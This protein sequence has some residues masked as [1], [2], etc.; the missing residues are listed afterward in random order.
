MLT[1]SS[2]PRFKFHW[3][4]RVQLSM[5]ERW[6]I[7]K[8]SYWCL[9]LDIFVWYVYVMWKGPVWFL[10]VIFSIPPCIQ[11]GWWSVSCSGFRIWDRL[12]APR[13]RPVWSWSNLMRTIRTPTTNVWRRCPACPNHCETP[14]NQWAALRS[15]TNSLKEQSGILGDLSVAPNKTSMSPLRFCF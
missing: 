9:S 14:A 13:G 11:S 3:L 12:Q 6:L 8:W 15:L 7:S 5:N 1:K 2:T 10:V 4:R